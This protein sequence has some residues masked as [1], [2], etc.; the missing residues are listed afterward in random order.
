[1]S[2]VA[3]SVQPVRHTGR[4]AGILWLF[5]VRTHVRACA[6]GSSVWRRVC[7]N[8]SPRFFSISVSA[9]NVIEHK[10]LGQWVK[11]SLS[12]A[13]HEWKWKEDAFWSFIIFPIA[14]SNNVIFSVFFNVL[15]SLVLC[16]CVCVLCVDHLSVCGSDC[17]DNQ[18]RLEG[19]EEESFSSLLHLTRPLW[20]L[21]L[22]WIC[23]TLYPMCTSVW[24]RKH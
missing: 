8:P 2:N 1:M 23:C 13:T 21:L 15:W 3:Q 20:T 12:A 10:P 17:G 24:S 11:P 14:M 16:V 22:H 9:I 19:G 18:S 6:E 5:T 7:V 4:K